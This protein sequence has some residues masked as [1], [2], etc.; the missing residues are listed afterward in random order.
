M[1]AASAN[2]AAGKL[3]PRRIAVLI[4]AQEFFSVEVNQ[5]I[6]RISDPD[7]GFPGNLRSK[8]TKRLSVQERR[9]EDQAR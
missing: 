3:S 9:H 4:R 5:V 2:C 8:F 1:T 7:F 6:W